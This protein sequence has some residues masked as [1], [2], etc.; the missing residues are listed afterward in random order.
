MSGSNIINMS[1]ASTS[2]SAA[3][4]D[5]YFF[6][7]LRVNVVFPVPPFPLK[8]TISF[9]LHPPYYFLCF[10]QYPLFL[11]QNPT[12]QEARLLSSRGQPSLKKVSHP[13]PLFFLLRRNHVL[14]C[15]LP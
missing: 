2:A 4:F 6:S 11:S 5:L 8:T 12:P 1:A 7:R 9:I 3:V 10:R 14:S 13:E 15:C